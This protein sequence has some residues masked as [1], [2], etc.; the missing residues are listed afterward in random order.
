MKKA[1]FFL[2]IVVTLGC[3]SK[4]NNK[5]NYTNPYC[6]NL[7]GAKL[8]IHDDLERSYFVFAPDNLSWT[9]L[10]VILNFHGYGGTIDDYVEEADL[11]ELVNSKNIILVYPQGSCLEGVPH[12]TQ[13]YPA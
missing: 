3:N 12:G 10:P 7:E 11:S 4:D 13:P 8:L 5:D 2:F 9:P 6:E 1:I